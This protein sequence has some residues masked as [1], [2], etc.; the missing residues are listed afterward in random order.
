MYLYVT[1]RDKHGKI[2]PALNQEDFVL[3]QDSH[4][5]TITHFIRQ[6]DLPLTLGLLVDT[7]LS[8]RNVLDEERD[9]GYRFL[10]QMLRDGKDEAFVI[11]FDHQVELLQDLTSSRPKLNAA[12]QL[13]QMPQPQF[14]NGQTT[15]A[16][17]VTEAT[18]PPTPTRTSRPA[19]AAATAATA[20]VVGRSSTMP[21]T[22]R[23]TTR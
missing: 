11:H 5:Q 7:S 18:T 2:V 10:D 4:P 19:L 8:Q 1:V 6:S 23:P 13:L 3:A 21:S 15:A 22:L 9:A 12:L 17:A 20:A 14:S 16:M